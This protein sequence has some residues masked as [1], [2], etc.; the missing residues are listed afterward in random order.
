MMAKRVK[1]DGNDGSCNV[2]D[3]TETSLNVKVHGMVTSLSPM[4]QREQLL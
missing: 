1:T 2:S 3:L 4:K